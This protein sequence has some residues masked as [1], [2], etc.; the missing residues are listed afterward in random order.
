M[1]EAM[2]Q[3]KNGKLLVIPATPTTLGHGTTGSLAQLYAK[4]LAEFL[5]SVPRT[6]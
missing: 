3:V 5:Q 6:Q 4:E 2:K 1:V